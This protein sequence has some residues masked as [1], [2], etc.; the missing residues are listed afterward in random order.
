MS[1]DTAVRK[2]HTMKKHKVTILYER[3]SCDDELQGTS[4]SILNQQQLLEEYAERNGLIPYIH[5]QDDGYSGSNWQR[6]GWQELIAKV[7]ANEVSCI[8]INVNPLNLYPYIR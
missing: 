1:G 3:L 4:N 2:G 5:F 6:P 8:C 7:E